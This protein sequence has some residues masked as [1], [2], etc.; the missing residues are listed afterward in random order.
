MRRPGEPDLDRTLT[1]VRVVC[2]R[3]TY[4]YTAFLWYFSNIILPIAFVVT[5]GPVAVYKVYFTGTTRRMA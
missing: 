1:L 2:R 3:I 4:D 5:S